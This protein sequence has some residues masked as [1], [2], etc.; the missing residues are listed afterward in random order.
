MERRR[1]LVLE[2]FL[3]A[4]ADRGRALPEDTRDV[5]LAGLR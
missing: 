4:A 3:L 1:T 5:D 2:T